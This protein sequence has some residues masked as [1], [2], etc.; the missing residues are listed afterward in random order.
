MIVIENIILSSIGLLF[1]V[2]LGLLFG[3]LFTLRMGI[4]SFNFYINA[5]LE[6]MVIATIGILFTIQFAGGSIIEASQA[7]KTVELTS[8]MY[9]SKRRQLVHK[10]FTSKETLLFIAGIITAGIGI[11][12]CLI[13]KSNLYRL[14]DEYFN[15]ILY[16]SKMLLF[17]I[18]II[19][20]VVLLLSSLLIVFSR[21]IILLW[22]CLGE[23]FW[24]RRKNYFTLALKQL[25]VNS[26]DYQKTILV[27]FAICLCVTPGLIVT[28]STNNH[29]QV[30]ANFGIGLCD[31]LITGWDG[32][33]TTILQNISTINGVE[34]CTEVEF[35]TVRWTAQGYEVTILNIFNTTAFTEVISPNFPDELVTYNLED[36]AQLTTNMSY[37]MSA[38]Y[39]HK[40]RYDRGRIYTSSDIIDPAEE[41]NNMMYINKF[42]TFPLVEQPATYFNIYHEKRYSLVMSNLTVS[43]LKEKFEGESNDELYYILV[44]ISPDANQTAIITEIENVSSSLAVET[45]EER[46]QI[47]QL[48]INDFQQSF[49]IIIMILASILLIFFGFVTAKDIYSQRLRITESKYNSGA[50]RSQ[51]WGNFSI[52]FLVIISVPVFLSML[53]TSILSYTVLGSLLGL[54]QVYKVFVPWLPWWLMGVIILMCVLVAFCGWLFEMIR[55]VN[56]YQPV[57]QE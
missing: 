12:G 48:S 46:L 11:I 5:F 44:N 18:L 3:Y 32:E 28:K 52:E 39:A 45:F 41:P 13:V 43:Q 25:S 47:L 8:E 50:K 53:L 42:D 14:T 21:F 34:L 30:E 16:Y 51:I 56:R 31:L 17:Q 4:R 54:P 37:M 24:K 38:E 10:F 15:Y 6:L 57:K 29:L 19:L 49:F 20:G 35:L 27:M 22:R 2:L 55:H 23:W 33:N 26:K 40:E 36:I 7:R 9:K 1:G